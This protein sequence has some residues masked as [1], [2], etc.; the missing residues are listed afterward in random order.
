MQS[1]QILKELDFER[2]A[3]G[4][5][6][7]KA[8]RIISKHLKKMGI[9]PK[10]EEFA[11]KSFDA[12]MASV[13]AGKKRWEVIP[14]GLCCDGD[15]RGE[16][17]YLENLDALAHRLGAYDDKIV[18]YYHSSRPVFELLESARLK[19]LINVSTPHKKA[20][21]R[22]LRQNQD[23]PIPQMTISYQDAEELMTICGKEITISI[24]Q[25]MEERKARNIVAEIPGTGHDNSLTM[26]VGHYDSV[27]RSHGSCDNAAG[28]VCLLQ[29]AEYF[30]KNP[31]KR[32]L[33]IVWFSGEEMGLLG[34]TA[35]MELHKEELLARLRLVINID[36]AGEVIGRNV[37]MVLGTKELMGYASG[38]LREEGIFFQEVLNI[39]SSDCMPFA[40]YEIPSL[41]IARLGGKALFYIHTEDDQ[42][43]YCNQEGIDVVAEAGI[44]L[45]RRILNAE[46]YPVNKAIDD[47]LREKIEKYM[48]NSTLGKPEMHWR[49][50][51]KK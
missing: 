9:K 40:T 27:A 38:L 37:L 43:K 32:D 34:S 3:G 24:R 42:A 14:Y 11:I 2:I 28:S 51:Y 47:S 35:Y 49:E 39:Y 29:A 8:I 5:G 44:T 7:S 23:S 46:F 6:E 20:G 50:S 33:R 15:I 13:I 12:G 1:Y 10:L 25:N 48:Y 45:L 16:L 36:L 22:A 4:E 21:V 19:A 30:S 18:L 41:N 17:V 31:P 26:L